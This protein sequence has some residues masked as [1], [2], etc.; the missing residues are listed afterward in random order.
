MI[1]GSGP[2]E[3][4]RVGLT[5]TVLAIAMLA[6][7]SAVGLGGPISTPEKAIAAANQ[8]VGALQV[9]RAEA[10]QMTWSDWQ[11]RS[12][13]AGGPIPPPASTS[14][15]WVVGLRGKFTRIRGSGTV[16]ILDR[17]TGRMIVAG[18]GPWDWP[19]YWDDL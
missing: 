15:V 18:T 4:R 1:L 10:K 7:G 3:V 19:P 5:M 12:G 6:C 16:V 8:A 13:N 2:E 14:P 17:K 11:Q 9:T